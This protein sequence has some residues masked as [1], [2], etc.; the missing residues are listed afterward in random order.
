MM[1]GSSDDRV[2]IVIRAA[3]KPLGYEE[4]RGLQQTAL[5]AFMAGSNVFLSIPMGGGK[6]LCYAVL[7]Q[8]KE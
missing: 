5:R 1:A 2:T 6:S 7:P 3:A 4:I 8:G